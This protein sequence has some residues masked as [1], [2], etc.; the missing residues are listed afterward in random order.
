MS[1]NCTFSNDYQASISIH[2]IP[3]G[4]DKDHRHPFNLTTEVVAKSPQPESDLAQD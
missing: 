4:R 2:T 3:D 1:I